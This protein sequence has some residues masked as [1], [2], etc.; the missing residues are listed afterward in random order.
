MAFIVTDYGAA[1]G[2]Q[3][4]LMTVENEFA[5]GRKELSLIFGVV[6]DQ[7]TVDAG[8]TPTTVLRAG[9]VLGQIAATKKW[10]HYSST[11]SDGSQVA[12]GILANPA[13]RMT[14]LNGNTQ[15]KWCSVVVG[16]PV[17]S[18]KLFGLDTM[19]RAQMFGRFVLDDDMVGNR[20][21]YLNLV[22]KTA[23]YQV[24]A[25]DNGTLFTT[26]GAAAEVD[27]TLPATIVCGSRFSFLNTVGQT[28]KV[29]APAGKL[30]TFNNAAATSVAFSTAG[31][32][33]G[34]QVDILTDETGAKYVTRPYGANTMTVA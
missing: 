18:A 26:T 10:K 33:I 4:E 11:A 21:A 20:F 2:P 27:F 19:A 32:L 31:N 17:Q 6:L 15:D 8:A 23:N 3:A 7:S 28:M 9:L 22:A 14:D 16:G 30:V 12:R 24:L 29:I 5:W 34:A 25:T 13:L 1:P